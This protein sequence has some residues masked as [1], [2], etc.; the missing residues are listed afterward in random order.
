MGWFGD[1]KWDPGNWNSLGD[2]PVVGDIY[3]GV[4][5]DPEGIKA[6]YDKQIQASKDAQAQL[7]HFLMG[8]KGQTLGYFAP[9]QHM[10]QNYYGTE[11]IQGP[12]IPKPTFATSYGGGK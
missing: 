3:K 11:G 5:G 1:S 6:A 9:A 2:V 12:Q 8:Q 4:T 10:F 7:Q